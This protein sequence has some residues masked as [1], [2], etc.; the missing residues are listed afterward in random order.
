MNSKFPADLLLIMFG[1]IFVSIIALSVGS[2]IYHAGEWGHGWMIFATVSVTLVALL[3]LFSRLRR[4]HR[5][6]SDARDE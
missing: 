2:L 5:P 6:G 4:R 1:P 3:L